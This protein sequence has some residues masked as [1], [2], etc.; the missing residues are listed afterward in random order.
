MIRLKF[1]KSLIIINVDGIHYIYS[2]R[3]DFFVKSIAETNLE[4]SVKYNN[5]LKIFLET[6]DTSS[7]FNDNRFIFNDQK[8]FGVFYEKPWIINMKMCDLETYILK[9]SI[10][11]IDSK[12]FNNNKDLM[13][14]NIF[15]NIEKQFVESIKD[16]EF[17][18][19]YVILNLV[20]DNEE[21]KG[22]Y[23]RLKR[24]GDNI[25]L[26]AF[27]NNT[28]SFQNKIVSSHYVKDS[29]SWKDTKVGNTCILY[30]EA[31]LHIYTFNMKSRKIKLQCYNIKFLKYAMKLYNKINPDTLEVEEIKEIAQPTDNDELK[32]QWVLYAISQKYF[33]VFYGEKLL[34]SAIKQNNIELIESI[35]NKTLEYFKKDPKNHI[36]HI[37]IDM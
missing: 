5:L 14:E 2:N 34:K 17:I 16:E 21:Q 11:Y 22:Y 20:N 15:F 33:L 37:I 1:F 3:M 32:K 8:V 13:N 9:D 35:Y 26:E 18:I 36:H 7:Y 19:K 6:D 4:N 25:I 12:E 27:I 30:N 24:S 10:N 28:N 29:K 23:M 31:E